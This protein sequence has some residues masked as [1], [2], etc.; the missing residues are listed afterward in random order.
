MYL[1]LYKDNRAEC[2]WKCRSANHEDIC[3]SS[4]GYASKQGAP[5][6]MALVKQGATAARIYDDTSKTW[7]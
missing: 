2:R 6:G 1:I 3:V 4:E 5:H 7:S